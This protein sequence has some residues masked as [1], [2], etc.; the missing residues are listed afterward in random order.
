MA[1]CFLLDSTRAT[2]LI[3]RWYASTKWPMIDR[4]QAVPLHLQFH[5]SLTPCSFRFLHFVL[6]AAIRYTALRNILEAFGTS[7][8]RAH[9]SVIRNIPQLRIITSSNNTLTLTLFSTYTVHPVL[10]GVMAQIRNS[11]SLWKSCSHAD[12]AHKGSSYCPIV[13]RRMRLYSVLTMNVLPV[14]S[15]SHPTALTSRLLQYPLSPNISS[16]PNVEKIQNITQITRH[17]YH[18]PR[19]N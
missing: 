13:R 3:R 14:Q 4:P 18:H 9:A 15:K 10:S 2:Q 6:R 12:R 7:F 5:I 19:Y 8:H 1:W 11:T 17:L 16:P